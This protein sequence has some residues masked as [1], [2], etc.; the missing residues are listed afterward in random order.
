MSEGRGD[1]NPKA[2]PVSSL[3]EISS[4]AKATLMLLAPIMVKSVGRLRGFGCCF[5]VG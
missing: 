2:A 5:T 3:C 1:V 4:R